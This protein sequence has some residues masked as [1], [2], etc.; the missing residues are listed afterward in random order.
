MFSNEQKFSSDNEAKQNTP[1]WFNDSSQSIQFKKHDVT[2]PFIKLSPPSNSDYLKTQQSF[3]FHELNKNIQSLDKSPFNV[4]TTP[5]QSPNYDAQTPFANRNH[6]GMY[7]F[8]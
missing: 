8:F 4:N 1:K 5:M 6:T 7:I 2:T 3:S